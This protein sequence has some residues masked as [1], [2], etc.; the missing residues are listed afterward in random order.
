M[1]LPISVIILASSMNLAFGARP[2]AAQNVEPATIPTV[3]AQ[4]LEMPFARMFGDRPHYV[5]G[6]TPQG[7]PRALQAP[8]S[9]KVIGGVKFGPMIAA[10][11][12]VPRRVNAM[13][14]Y[15]R[16]LANAGYKRGELRTGPRGGFTSGEPPRATGWCS[17]AGSASVGVFDSTA[18]SRFVVVSVASRPVTA[19]E[20]STPEPVGDRMKPPLEIPTLAAPFGVLATP[21]GTGWSGDNMRTS[22]VVDTTMSADSLLGHYS[23]QLSAAGW[24]VGKRLSD[25]D[26]ALQSLSVRDP[27]GKR[28]VGALTVI[29]AAD[30]RTVTL[31]M[32]PASRE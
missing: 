13:E 30:R 28:W 7:W 27:D 8:A 23:A 9:A 31:N 1:K 26:N 15:D 18:T 12:R 25:G 29:T 22:V 6:R 17:P 24:Q 16:M 14:T 10:V 20:C 21:G 2:L 11:Y 4:V 5:V 19:P 3:L 32:M